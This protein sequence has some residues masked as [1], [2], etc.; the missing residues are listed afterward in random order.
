MRDKR[1]R[2]IMMPPTQSTGAATKWCM[3]ETEETRVLCVIV[4][5]KSTGEKARSWTRGVTR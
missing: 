4:F 2:R 3:R 5:R 1:P